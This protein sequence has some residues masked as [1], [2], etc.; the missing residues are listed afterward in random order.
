MRYSVV[1]TKMHT[2]DRTLSVATLE[3]GSCALSSGT[4]PL[5]RAS[6]L[7][8]VLALDAVL[9]DIK[10]GHEIGLSNTFFFFFFP[11]GLTFWHISS[12]SSVLN[13]TKQHNEGGKV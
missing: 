6:A 12:L 1:K 13:R 8:L 7:S 4:L 10:L 5:S 2:S 9:V 11:S 3:R